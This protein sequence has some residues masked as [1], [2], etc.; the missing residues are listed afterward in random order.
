[1]DLQIVLD[2]IAAA[3]KAK[4]SKDPNSKEHQQYRN[5]VFLLAHTIYHELGHVFITFLSLGESSTPEKGRSDD[6]TFDEGDRPEAGKRVEAL[7]FGGKIY[8]VYDDALDANQVC[9]YKHCLTQDF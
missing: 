9:L 8:H 6:H 1:M 4:E 5:Y 3:R 7:V 2:I